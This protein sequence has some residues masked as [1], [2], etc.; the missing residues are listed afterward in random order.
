MKCPAIPNYPLPVYGAYGG[1]Q[2]DGLPI[3]CSGHSSNSTESAD[4]LTFG[5]DGWKNVSIHDVELGKLP[6]YTDYPPNQYHHKLLVHG[7]SRHNLRHDGFYQEKSIPSADYADGLCAAFMNPGML[8]IMGAGVNHTRAYSQIMPDTNEFTLIKAETKHPRFRA[9]CG[10]IRID[11]HSLKHAMIIAGGD[12]QLTSELLTDV[13][14]EWKPG[15]GIIIELFCNRPKANS[16]S[17]Q[18]WCPANP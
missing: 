15:P 9:G 1:A 7:S 10:R 14:L 13:T 16:F 17:I 18:S 12:G 3:I 8:I 6:A 2:L 5:K 11:Q 4:C